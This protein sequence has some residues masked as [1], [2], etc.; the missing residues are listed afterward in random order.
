MRT[1]DPSADGRRSA[2]IF[3][4]ELPSAAA[5][6]LAAPGVIL[7]W[8][9]GKVIRVRVREGGLELRVRVGVWGQEWVLLRTELVPGFNVMVIG[10]G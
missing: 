9:Y 10:V 5:Y 2:A 6:R 4:I 7:C 3:A 1:A 8:A